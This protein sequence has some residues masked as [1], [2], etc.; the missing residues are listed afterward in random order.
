MLRVPVICSDTELSD[1]RVCVIP[2]CSSPAGS[3][4][5]VTCTC[6]GAGVPVICSDTELSDVRV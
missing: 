4:R 6:G 3:L 2:V 5:C 1:I